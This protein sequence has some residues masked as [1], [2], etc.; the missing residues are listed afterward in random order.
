MEERLSAPYNN[1]RKEKKNKLR[2]IVVEIFFLEEYTY[3]N[4]DKPSAMVQ[5][6]SF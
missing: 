1:E 2:T 6:T 5:N 4:V 3:K